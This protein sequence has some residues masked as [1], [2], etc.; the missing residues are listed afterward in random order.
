MECIGLSA[1]VECF[2]FFYSSF[3]KYISLTTFTNPTSQPHVHEYRFL[4]ILI[5][6]ICL[7][8]LSHCFPLF[9]LFFFF[10]FLITQKF[11]IFFLL[12][13]IRNIFI[14]FLFFFH[15]WCSLLRHMQISNGDSLFSLYLFRKTN[16]KNPQV[17]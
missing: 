9:F 4:F 10:I 1:Y 5:L 7:A 8:P 14:Y 13:Y 16:N 15:L 3:M 11:F 12:L 6:S 2:A 17:N